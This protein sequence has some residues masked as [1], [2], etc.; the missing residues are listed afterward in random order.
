MFGDVIDR[1]VFVLR[2]LDV[3]NKEAISVVLVAN[4]ED[5]TV[6][7][8]LPAVALSIKDSNNSTTYIGGAIQDRLNIELSVI[9]N[10][11]NF[12]WSGD[13]KVQ[14]KVISIAH[15][16]RDEL[17]LAQKA[18][19]FLCLKNKYDFYLRYNGFTTFT[20]IA[21]RKTMQ[22]EVLVVQLKF[23][24]PILDKCLQL[25]MNKTEKVD[26]EVIQYENLE[27]KIP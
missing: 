16:F 5:G 8:N 7:T 24:T 2:T 1:L 25:S 11:T 22:E 3:V 19:M 10:L 14:A 6:N 23:S 4:D 18:G 20:R 15:R 13:S 9:V 17:M 26:K 12:S 21:V 27:T